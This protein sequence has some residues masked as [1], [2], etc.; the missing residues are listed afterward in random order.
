MFSHKNYYYTLNQNP[1]ILLHKGL[2]LYNI[3][4]I[5]FIVIKDVC[6]RVAC[7]DCDIILK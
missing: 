2:N 4:I 5:K 6:L 3:E 1:G 7:S